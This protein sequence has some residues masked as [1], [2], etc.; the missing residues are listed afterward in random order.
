MTLLKRGRETPP[1]PALARRRL[2]RRH[3][4]VPL[5]AL[6]A[7]ALPRCTTGGL[8]HEVKEKVKE[9]M[10]SMQELHSGASCS[11]TTFKHFGQQMWC[12][13]DQRQQHAC[14]S[15]TS[16]QFPGYKE[17][18]KKKRKQWR[19]YCCVK[20]QVHCPKV[21]RNKTA[22]RE[23]LEGLRFDCRIT[24]ST[25]LGAKRRKSF[26][27]SI[28]AWASTLPHLCRPRRSRHAV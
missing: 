14:T 28:G 26:A 5:F 25:R 23:K 22:L 3:L 9:K 17:M 18:P 21:F 11:Q 12:C 16:C 6:L 15:E 19:R 13:I 4:G 20:E 27:T 2:S 1:P 7:M 24:I 10:K 8:F